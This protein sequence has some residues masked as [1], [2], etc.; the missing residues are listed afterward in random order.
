MLWD[1][2][3]PALVHRRPSNPLYRPLEDRASGPSRCSGTGVAGMGLLIQQAGDHKIADPAN[4]F[5]EPLERQWAETW[6]FDATAVRYSAAM[7]GAGHTT[8]EQGWWDLNAA[9]GHMQET[10]HQWLEK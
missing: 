1:S 9:L 5:D 4:L 10:I 2:L 7:G 6:L 3:I 8:F